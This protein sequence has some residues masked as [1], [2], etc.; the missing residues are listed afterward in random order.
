MQRSAHVSKMVSGIALGALLILPGCVPVDWVKNIF[1]GGSSGSQKTLSAKAGMPLLTLDG[2]AVITDQSLEAEFKEAL[3][4]QPMY[5]QLA[6]Q[7]KGMRYK[8]LREYYEGVKKKMI[9]TKYVRDKKLDQQASYQD[10]LQQIIE[11]LKTQLDIK[12]FVEQH[13][14][15][16]DESDIKQYYEKNKN[17]PQGGILLSQGGIKAAGVYFDNEARAQEFVQKIKTPGADFDVIAKQ[18]NV[19]VKP[20]DI[21]HERTTGLP[22]VL[23]QK[24]LAA[25]KF[26]SSECVKVGGK[27]FCVVQYTS[28]EKTKYRP[29]DQVHELIEQQLKQE[30]LAEVVNVETGKLLIKYGADEGMEYWEALQKEIEP[31]GAA[32]MVPG[33]PAMLEAPIAPQAPAAS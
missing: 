27:S 31:A 29:Y 12:A 17:N 9:I 23:K 32:P 19:A 7:H 15:T 5:Q 2:K 10:E 30:R 13:P 1:G 11:Q 16:I 25:R 3:S 8:L 6:E 26:P 14:V 4:T 24:I 28:K 33:M 21:V 18:E 22:D 20:F